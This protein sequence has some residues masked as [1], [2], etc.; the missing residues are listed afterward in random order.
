MLGKLREFV[1]MAH[2]LDAKNQATRAKQRLAGAEAELDLASL[3]TLGSLGKLN[4]QFN[5]IGHSRSFGQLAS[6]DGFGR[7]GLPPGPASASLGPGPGLDMKDR[8]SAMVDKMTND[9]MN[10]AIHHMWTQVVANASKSLTNSMM[11]LIKGQ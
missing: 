2:Q 7:A 10:T 9:A 1:E 11:T 5:P 3:D 6:H 4:S 8:A